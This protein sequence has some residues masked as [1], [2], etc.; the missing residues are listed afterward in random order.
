MLHTGM[1]QEKGDMLEDGWAMFQRNMEKDAGSG[2]NI[3]FEV[4]DNG[5]GMTPE[6]R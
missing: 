5:C 2:E 3:L 6:V 1:S 4:T